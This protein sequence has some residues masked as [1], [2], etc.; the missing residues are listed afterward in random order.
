M[1]FEVAE[2]WQPFKQAHNLGGGPAD[3]LLVGWGHELV[4]GCL[5]RYPPDRPAEADDG[6]IR[7]HVSE[8]WHGITLD[9]RGRGRLHEYFYASL[10][11]GSQ[12]V[13]AA[14][15]PEASGSESV[16]TGWLF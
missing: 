8:E 11:S 9:G 1:G 12:P 6:A 7:Q 3:A 10:Y 2:R 5:L 15:E 4:L 16:L 14:P 13:V